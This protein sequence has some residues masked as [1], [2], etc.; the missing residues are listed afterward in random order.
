MK[1]IKVAHYQQRQQMKLKNQRGESIP[2]MCVHVH[3]HVHVCVL[4]LR[5]VYAGSRGGGS[6]V[7]IM[8]A[9]SLKKKVN[10]TDLELSQR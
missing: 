6:L 8:R 1:T 9:Q 5:H 7:A 10:E 3:V 2:N 4:S